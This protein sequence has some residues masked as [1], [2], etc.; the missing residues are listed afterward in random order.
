VAMEVAA[1][2][3]P[4]PLRGQTKV[5]QNGASSSP[6]SHSLPTPTPPP[7]STMLMMAMVT[8]PGLSHTIAP[9][10]FYPPPLAKHQE[11]VT[12]KDVFLDTLNKFHAALGT[13]LAIPKMGGKDLDLHVLYIEVTQRGG[14]HQVIKDR[15]WKE[16]TGAFN[17]PRTT[18]SASYVLRKYYITLLHHYEQ[19][20]FFGSRGPLI[21]PPTPLPAPSPVMTKNEYTSEGYSQGQAHEEESEALTADGKKKRRKL[22][23]VQMTVPVHPV[24]SIGHVVTGAIEGKFEHGYLV[25]VVVGGEKLRGVI[26]HI[27]PGH[28]GPQ[29]A[30]VPNYAL[31]T[32]AEI[33]LPEKDMKVRRKRYNEDSKKDPN[34]PRQNRTGYNFFFAEERAKLKL[35]HPD[36][37]RELSRM[38][39]DAWNG[40]SEEAKM[41]YQDKGVKDK[42]R[43]KREMR[44]YKE[45][46]NNPNAGHSSARQVEPAAIIATASQENN[47]VARVASEQESPTVPVPKHSFNLDQLPQGQQSEA[48]AYPPPQQYLPPSL[49]QSSVEAP[50]LNLETV[51]DAPSHSLQNQGNIDLEA[52]EDT[53]SQPTPHQFM[54]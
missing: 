3:A 8:P 37:E 39:G 44:E 54:G 25:T 31:T 10:Q 19:A 46:L 23:P 24:A 9:G 34:A 52:N 45:Q 22:A 40:L 26:Y 36:K 17:F 18:T 33:Q 4:S 49:P 6:T 16:I 30:H 35:L 51:A 28:R 32:G 5:T 1:P 41:P 12:S 53:H 15:K 20:Y 14:L 29:Y 48:P 2:S 47:I 21:P 27:P 7:N 50:Q 11:V 43:Y 13:R 38:I 42:E